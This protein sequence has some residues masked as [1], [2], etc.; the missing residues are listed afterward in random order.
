MARRRLPIP[1]YADRLGLGWGSIGAVTISL[2]YR[3]TSGY[4][5]YM[6]TVTFRL[7]PDLYA[8]LMDACAREDMSISDIARQGVEYILMTMGYVV[9]PPPEPDQ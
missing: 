9:Q 5:S 1:R 4:L 7:P 2:A 3:K 6:P 8:C